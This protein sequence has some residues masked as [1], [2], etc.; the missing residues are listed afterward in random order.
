MRTALWMTGLALPALVAL[1]ISVASAQ[2]QIPATFYGSVTIDGKPAP[3][4]SEVRALINGLDCSQPAPGTRPVIRDG[5]NSAYVLSVVHE[6]QRPGCATDGATVTF[7]I[8]GSLAVQSATWHPGPIPLDLS[9]GAA[10]PIPLPSPTGSVAA[11]LASE[12][13]ALDATPSATL[14]RPT[15]TPPT[16]DVHFGSVTPLP[17]SVTASG[18][19]VG[20]DDGEGLPILLIAVLVLL[21]LGGAIGIALARRRPKGS[22]GA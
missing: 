15:G 1:S 21:G 6:S 5:G 7:T 9:V 18:P 8:D 4:G 10:P 3:D 2:P 19:A 14:S 13:A 12:T 20:M 16:D 22:P 17:G 11:A